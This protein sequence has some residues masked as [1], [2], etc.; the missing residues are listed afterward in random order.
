MEKNTDNSSSR[1][2][3]NS[4]VNA[5]RTEIVESQKARIDLLKY[6]L[7]AVAGLGSFALGSLGTKGLPA[8]D[9]GLENPILLILTLI[10][11]VCIYVDL[12]CQHNTMRILVIAQYLKHGN[13]KYENF[14][15]KMSFILSSIGLYLHRVK[16]NTGLTLDL[17]DI[18]DK[19][20]PTKFKHLEYIYN[21]N[22]M[23]IENKMESQ[24]KPFSKGV[25]HF[26]ELEDLALQ[27]STIFISFLLFMGSSFDILLKQKEGIKSLKYYMTN[28]I[29]ILSG[30]SG[31]L[32]SYFFT[33]KFEKHK[34]AL[35]SAALRMEEM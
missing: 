6:K 35:F 12:V 10:P 16:S 14:L 20:D 17:D 13:C 2:L 22:S 7:I 5:L 29:L 31:I 25:G 24:K 18:S 33:I 15:C 3:E 34:K 21:Y 4:L 30:L 8:N 9:G 23:S 28:N 19:S 26:F 32:I 27:G 1:N 11:L